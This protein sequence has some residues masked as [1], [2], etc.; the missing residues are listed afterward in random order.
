MDPLL[1]QDIAGKTEF[2]CMVQTAFVL[3]SHLMSRQETS[4]QTIG[5]IIKIFLSS[6]HNFDMTFGYSKDSTNP[7]WYTK[8]NFISLLNL[9]H[10][11][12]T[13]GP[14]Y[15]YWEGVKERYIQYVKPILKNKR[16]SVSFLCTK[17]QQSLRQNALNILKEQHQNYEFKTYYR[18]SDIHIFASKTDLEEHIKNNDCITIMIK[19]DDNKIEYVAICKCNDTMEY[20]S[21]L[22][23]D[24]VGYHK[25]NLW[26]SPVKLHKLN[27]DEGE[28]VRDIRS[29]YNHCAILISLDFD[30]ES[31]NLNHGY[32]LL[33]SNWMTRTQNGSLE[34]PTLSREL[35]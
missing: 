10:Q 23:D 34:L 32:T 28:L 15:L 20:Y 11:I 35:F 24:N 13:Y 22:F 17:L 1:D 4:V 31:S 16:K 21:V 19:E 25:Y 33:S 5:D 12:N 26:F 8:S 29:I 18:Y 2:K 6:C 30:R 7:F 27:I 3:V 14:L 9:P